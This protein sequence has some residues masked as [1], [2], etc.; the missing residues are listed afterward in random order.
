MEQRD[1][2]AAGAGDRPVVRDHGQRLRGKAAYRDRHGLAVDAGQSKVVVVLQRDRLAGRRGRG[3]HRR[4]GEMDVDATGARRQ[5]HGRAGDIRGG[6]TRRHFQNRLAGRERDRVGGR[7]QLIDEDVGCRIG[8][9]QADRA[10]RR[11]VGG[12]DRALRRDVDVGVVAADHRLQF[13]A[14]GADVV[15]DDVLVFLLHAGRQDVDVGID[16]D[17]TRRR[18]QIRRVGD[19]IGHASID[20]ILENAAVGIDRDRARG[21]AGVNLADGGVAAAASGADGERRRATGAQRHRLDVEAVV[22]LDGKRGPSSRHRGV[23]PRRLGEDVGDVRGVDSEIAG[24]RD[25][26]RGFASGRATDFT[27]GRRQCHV[28]LGGDRGVDEEVAGVGCQRHVGVGARALW[29]DGPGDGQVGSRERDRAIGGRGT[30][31]RQVGRR[32]KSDVAGV[33]AVDGDDLIGA[34]AGGE[35]VDAVAKLAR[36]VE[37]GRGDLRPVW[38]RGHTV[39]RGDQQLVGRHH[40]GCA[41]ECQLPRVAQQRDI[42]DPGRAAR[43]QASIDGD[44]RAGRVGRGRDV[45]RRG[46]DVGTVEPG[47]RHGNAAVDGGEVDVAEGGRD[48]LRH[49]VAVDGGQRH[50]AGRAGGAGGCDRYRGERAI[51]GDGDA[52]GRRRAD[53]LQFQRRGVGDHDR[54][55]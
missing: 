47:L 21:G 15:D 13:Q 30:F 20:D 37:S 22:I 43:V 16:H 51:G 38:D 26:R 54:A 35:R 40:V 19:D 18:R 41:G 25:Q 39:G 31:D 46:A 6:V 7:R 48:R 9:G 53:V 32:G 50:V 23:E 55:G 28:A 17:L 14:R 45:T 36:E 24:S 5:R 49:H 10:G 27:G 52:T 8:R 42:T 4:G 11:H 33:R 1:V 34:K 44:H 2:L 29:Q 12:G 3:G